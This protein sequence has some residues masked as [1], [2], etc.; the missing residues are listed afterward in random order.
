MSP[1]RLLALVCLWLI[2]A[3]ARGA[4]KA[5]PLGELPLWFVD[6]G[7]VEKR[8]GVYHTVH[9]AETLD[10]PVIEPERPWEGGRLY[11]YGSVYADPQ[12]N[13]LRM[14]YMSCST[15]EQGSDHVLMATSKDGL[16]WNKPSLG[17]V[18]FKGSRDNNIVFDLHSPSV[19]FDPH[20]KD[21]ARRYKLLGSQKAKGKGYRGYDAAFSPDG[22]H[23]SYHPK[24]PALASSDTIT[25]TQN[26]QTG[27]YLAYHKRPMA[28]DQ[29]RRRVVWLSRSAD[30]NTW[31]EPELV[32]VP[33]AQDD[34][35]VKHA[36]ERT[37]IYNLSVFPHAAG[38]LGLPTMF[39]VLAEQ[40]RNTVKPAQSPLD[41]PID[42]QFVTSIDGRTW[43]HKLPRDN[44]IPRGAP[45]TFDGGAI[46]GVSSTPVHVGDKTW[47]YYTAI[48]T[49]H[50]GTLPTKRLTIG[51]AQWRRD[52]FVSLDADPTGGRIET[53]SLR[54]AG[55]TLRVNANAARGELRVALREVD[56][57]S[58]AGYALDDCQP[59]KVDSTTW[60]V[61]WRDRT[62]VPT[63]RPVH[64][65]IELKSTS[66]YS[67]V[68]G[69]APK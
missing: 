38:F 50:G 32:L 4:E 55:P 36:P 14:W 44:V 48:N 28:Q 47:V 22:L 31:T 53:K 56:G 52:G 69:N 18:E 24:N 67:L 51:R 27:E 21:P 57:R 64:V 26:P 29:Y 65:V 45:G 68:S 42:V 60:T 43:Q 15:A 46:L 3:S 61:K 40:P 10:K 66:L 13:E 62:A 12:S 37:E 17:I 19:L 11:I 58:I 25:L 7:G 33:D 16:D 39:R 1:R 30:F 63:D 54:L 49:G 9:K 8:T 23:W 5:I 6:D 20:E 2:V 59:M 41:G 34:A 35:W